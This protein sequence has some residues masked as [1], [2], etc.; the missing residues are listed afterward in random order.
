M[1]LPKEN[2][3]IG[4]AM[5]SSQ[6]NENPYKNF[7]SHWHGEL[8]ANTNIKGKFVDVDQI[9]AYCS[10][11]MNDYCEGGVCIWCYPSTFNEK[12]IDWNFINKIC[13]CK[14][15]KG[16]AVGCHAKATRF[17]SRNGIIWAIENIPKVVAIGEPGLDTS[18]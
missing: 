13:N 16:N 5:L 9:D 15:N 3:P 2:R 7:D 17:Y 18:Q 4:L 6:L 12:S 8:V 1:L 14:W 11:K 10:F